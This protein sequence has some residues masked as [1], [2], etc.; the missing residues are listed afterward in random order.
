MDFFTELQNLITKHLN[1]GESRE[2]VEA[3]LEQAMD[4]MEDEDK[5][6]AAEAASDDEVKD[7]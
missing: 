3:D 1:G 6:E 7:E 2:Q 5:A 4:L